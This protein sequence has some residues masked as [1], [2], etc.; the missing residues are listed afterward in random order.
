MMS[1]G[2]KITKI[3][4]TKY[5]NCEFKKVR[6]RWLRN[7]RTGRNLELDL[8]NSE[9]FV[10]VEYQGEQHYHYSEYFHKGN[11]NNFY[12][13]QFRDK[14]KIDRCKSLGIDLIIIPYY[15]DEDS[16]M[17]HIMEHRSN[18]YN[19]KIKAIKTVYNPRYRGDTYISKEMSNFTGWDDNKL[20]DKFDVAMFIV[21]Y[22]RE[23]NLKYMDLIFPDEKLQ[24]LLKYDPNNSPIDYE[25]GNHTLLT[26]SRIQQY[27]QRHY[28]KK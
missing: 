26:N 6:P 22:I 12:E 24:K 23:N 9:K 10:A 21:K 18:M 11:I 25:T 8:Y 2:E 20:Y 19:E 27:I 16:I 7:P 28:M 13:Q 14:Y 4:A 15:I 17:T 5:F 3:V 1:Y